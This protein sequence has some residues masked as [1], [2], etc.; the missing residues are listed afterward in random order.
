MDHSINAARP[1]AAFIEVSRDCAVCQ[2]TSHQLGDSGVS[3][4]DSIWV[5]L[6][7]NATNLGPFKISFNFELKTDLKIS[8]IC[9]NLTIL[10]Q[11]RGIGG[12]E[13]G[14]VLKILDTDIQKNHSLWYGGGR[15][16]RRGD[17]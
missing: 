3:W 16:G 5:I 6:A 9:P 8:P 7:P 11:G 15:R 17:K 13:K 10:T 4:S 12:G 2:N 1:A 14:V